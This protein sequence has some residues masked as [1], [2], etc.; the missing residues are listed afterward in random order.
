MKLN[1]DQIKIDSDIQVR[2]SINKDVVSSYAYRM[3]EGDQFP[4]VVIFHDEGSEY[5]LADGFHRVMAAK[6]I[7]A[8]DIEVV[9]HGGTAKD[10]LW[11]ALGANREH[12]QRLTS[13]D[14]K[15]AIKSALCSFPDKTQWM[16][17]EQIGC[18]QSYVAKV[19]SEYHSDIEI[20][21][22]IKNSRGQVRPTSYKRNPV[23]EE[24]HYLETDT[25]QEEQ[26]YIDPMSKGV[27]TKKVDEDP[28]ADNEVITGLRRYWR[29]ANKKEKA[30]FLAW[31]KEVN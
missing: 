31:I 20:P 17:A 23:D 7:N 12:G 1:L 18:T 5:F 15:T 6:E 22:T 25:K 11:F 16:I 24:S 9:I 26:K 8:K 30:R 21:A 14:V 19:K 28:D 4:P 10:A 3:M 29:K 2:T 27:N 13:S